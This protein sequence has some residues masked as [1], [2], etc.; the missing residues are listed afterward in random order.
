M[1]KEKPQSLMMREIQIVAIETN[2]RTLIKSHPE[3]KNFIET[4][5][6]EAID[7]AFREISDR[8]NYLE[9]DI[10]FLGQH[11]SPKLKE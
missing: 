4:L 8:L 3:P 11:I 7:Q 2:I 5:R 6:N 9:K 1:K 10:E